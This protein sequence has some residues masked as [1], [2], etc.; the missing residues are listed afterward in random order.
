MQVKRTIRRDYIMEPI[1]REARRGGYAKR[2][3]LL[4]Q[5]QVQDIGNTQRA[6]PE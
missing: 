4:L 2:L 1:K 3:A 5:V 6:Q